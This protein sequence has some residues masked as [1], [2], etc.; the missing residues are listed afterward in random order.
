MQQEV[1]EK[2]P[3]LDVKV[4]AVWFKM[5]GT[6]RKS[7]WPAD[8]LTDPRVVHRWDE[9]RSVGL[10]YAK[11]LP[12]LIPKAAPEASGLDQPVPVLWDA[13]LIYAPDAKWAAQP[14]GLVRWGRTILNSRGTMGKEFAKLAGK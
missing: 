2:Y 10:W 5:Y 4:Y 11:Q 13:I 14:A 9:P 3:K 6:D 8:V 12:K 7:A 1:L